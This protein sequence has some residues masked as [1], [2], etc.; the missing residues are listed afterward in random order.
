VPPDGRLRDRVYGLLVLINE[1]EREKLGIKPN[2]VGSV[3]FTPEVTILQSRRIS[4]YVETLRL[5]LG[6]FFSDD[7]VRAVK[8]AVEALRK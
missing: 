1:K 3:H 8:Q 5:V 7:A 2:Y 4:D 6:L